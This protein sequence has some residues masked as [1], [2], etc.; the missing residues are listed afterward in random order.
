M[1]DDDDIQLRHID[2]EHGF[3]QAE[4]LGC[5]RSPDWE[6]RASSAPSV[7]GRRTD[8]RFALA[9]IASSPVCSLAKKLEGVEVLLSDEYRKI[10]RRKM[11]RFVSGLRD[12]DKRAIRTWV[13]RVHRLCPVTVPPPLVESQK[14]KSDDLLMDWLQD[15]SFASFVTSQDSFCSARSNATTPSTDVVIRLK[16]IELW[17]RAVLAPSPSLLSY[18]AGPLLRCAASR[19]Q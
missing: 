11:A 2:E 12:Q 16:C 18:Y 13:D 5:D 1:E 6:V 8:F 9:A 19:C 3:A 4:L 10:S 14:Q 15:I 7:A 17:L